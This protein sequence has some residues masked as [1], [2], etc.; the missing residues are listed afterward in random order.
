MQDLTG[1]VFGR[2]HVKCRDGRVKNLITWLCICDCGKE[3][4]VPAI[5]LTRANVR[6]CGCLRREVTRTNRVTHGQSSHHVY[7]VWQS[8]KD[9]CG[10]PKNTAYKNYG[11]RGIYVC[12]QWLE[13]FENFSSDMGPRPAGLTIERI[14]NNGPYSPINCKWATRTEQRLNRRKSA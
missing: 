12:D 5:Y 6:S 7:W 8:M 11:G 14:D 4:I 13:S 3:K 2:L 1:R 10:N 9:R